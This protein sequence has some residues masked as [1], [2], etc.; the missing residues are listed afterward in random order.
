MQQ[1]TVQIRS[2]AQVRDFVALASRQPFDVLVGN[3]EHPINAKSLFAMLGLS[4]RHPL[5]VRA[6]CDAAAFDA[7]RQEAAPFVVA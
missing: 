4:Y 6:E 3:T 1:M 7:F 5:Q 2:F